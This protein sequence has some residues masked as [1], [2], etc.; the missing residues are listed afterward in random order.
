M[1]ILVLIPLH[2]GLVMESTNNI[3]KFPVLTDSSD[4]SDL[5]EQPPTTLKVI[6]ASFSGCPI[7]DRQQFVNSHCILPISIM[8][9]K[10]HEANRFAATLKLINASFKSCTLLV[11]DT[12][13]RHTLKIDHPSENMDVLTNKAKE[14]GD[15]WLIRNKTAYQNLTI[16]YYIFRWDKYLNHP[17]FLEQ[18]KMVSELYL[19]DAVFKNS[20]LG[21][22]KEYLDRYFNRNESFQNYEEAL[23]CCVEY[24]KEECAGMCLWVEGGYEFEVYPTGR[25]QALAM[26]Y[27][28]II[29]PNYPNLLRPV[30]IRFKK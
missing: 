29:H 10:E 23:A 25:T 26:T 15:G 21:S 8:G 12:L 18:Y 6:K 1:L 7:S 28:S 13:Y 9:R 11:V 5:L 30:G 16:P 3:Y 2:L 14:A 22:S 17:G 19:N 4:S 24:L 20:I 27:Q